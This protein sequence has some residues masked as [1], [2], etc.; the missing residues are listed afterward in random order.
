MAVNWWLLG[1]AFVVGFAITL[2]LVVRRVEREVALY[3]TAFG[4]ATR[5]PRDED[6]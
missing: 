5:Q 4:A 2:A 3:E 6:G 1:L